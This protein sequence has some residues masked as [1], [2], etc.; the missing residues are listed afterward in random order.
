MGWRMSWTLVI[1][2]W[3]K[4]LF[5]KTEILKH[6]M[7]VKWWASIHPGQQ[8][9]LCD[10]ARP[11][12]LG[13]QRAPFV[14]SNQASTCWA[15]RELLLQIASRLPLLK[16]LAFPKSSILPQTKK[17]R[18]LWSNKKLQEVQKNKRVVVASMT[19]LVNWQVRL[20]V[21]VFTS[22]CVIDRA[23]WEG[24]CR[25]LSRSCSIKRC[26]P[27][28]LSSICMEL[29]CHC[30]VLLPIWCDTPSLTLYFFPILF[31]VLFFC[32]FSFYLQDHS[33]AR[34]QVFLSKWDCVISCLN[35]FLFPK[36]PQ[37]LWPSG[38]ELAIAGLEI[39]LLNPTRTNE[40]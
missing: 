32:V 8:H 12:A 22:R 6:H 38:T 7:R 27:W 33:E 37:C 3:N 31:S 15:V 29:V 13:A 23:T 2:R 1:L 25:L 14:S 11:S 36:I 19:T 9:V 39:P 35:V 28:L 10:C 18:N 20:G 17:K 26:A 5:Y 16:I 30:H 34:F 24:I 40:I 21:A 4:R